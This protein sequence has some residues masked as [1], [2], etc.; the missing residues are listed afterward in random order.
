[1]P[2]AHD[3][4]VPVA[5]RFCVLGLVLTLGAM[6][7]TRT[8]AQ[9][10]DTIRYVTPEAARTRPIY[11]YADDVT[12]WN[13]GTTQVVALQGKVL[14]E[15]G[16]AVV[17][18]ERAVAWMESSH[19]TR[20]SR[21]RVYA[22]G[23][24]HGEAGAKPFASSQATLDLS[25]YRELHVKSYSRKI[26]RHSL[27]GSPLVQKAAEQLGIR[28]ATATAQAATPASGS[29]P[30]PQRNTLPASPPGAIAPT[31]N[32]P[33][34]LPEALQAAEPG[35]GKIV[36]TGG[37]IPSTGIGNGYPALPNTG[38][39][40][41]GRWTSSD[42]NAD[43]TLPRQMPVGP[44]PLDPV[45]STPLSRV[46]TGTPAGPTQGS[47]PDRSFRSNAPPP[48]DPVPGSSALNG[49]STPNGSTVPNPPALVP[50]APPP[51]RPN[52]PSTNPGSYPP[53]NTNVPPNPPPGAISSETV[54]PMVQNAL[55]RVIQIAP[56]FSV[57]FQLKFFPV[58]DNEQACVIT[59]GIILTVRFQ[60]A[61]K[62]LV[63]DM[64]AD[65]VVIWTRGNSQE[66]LEGMRA[67]QEQGNDREI[68]FYLQGNVIIRTSEERNQQ[69]LRADRVYYDV[70]K[71]RAIARNADLEFV[72]PGL[73]AAAHVKAEE[74]WQLSRTEYE[75]IQA[76]IFSS[77][78]P[79]NP[80]LQLSL[81]RLNI[82]ERQV[83]TRGW[84]EKLLTG[85]AEPE[86]ALLARQHYFRGRNAMLRVTEV[87]FFYLPYLQGDA[88]DP[89]GPL[90]GISFGQDVVFG[91]QVYTTWDLVELLGLRKRA[92]FDWN[93][94]A[95][96]LSE[97]GFGLGSNLDYASP[98]PS[99]TANPYRGSIK[100]YWIRDE[101]EDVLPDRPST[102]G[103]PPADRGR[104]LWRHIQDFGEEWSV[105]AQVSYLS[106]HNFL[107]Q[108][109]KFEFD[110]GQNQET[111]AYTKWQRGIYSASL[112]AQQNIRDWVTETSWLPRADGYITGLSLFD[113]FTYHSWASA[114]YAD[115]HVATG[116][117]V[118]PPTVPT[119][120]EVI[121]GRF[122]WMQELSLPF[123]LGPVKLAPYGRIDLTH[124]TK[125]LT[126]EDDSRFLGGGGLRASMPLSRL[127]PEARSELLNVNGIFHKIV[128]S[129]NYY[130]AHST[131]TYLTL[132]QLDR[133]NDDAVDQSLRDITPRQTN[134]VLGPAGAALQS[135]PIFN[136]QEYA[137]RRLIDHR[138][139]TLES[140]QVLQADIRQRWQTKRGYPGLEH[141]IDW[142]TLDVSASFFPNPI[143]DNYGKQWAFL[144]YQS[145]WYVGD[146]TGLSAT[147][148]FDPFENGASYWTLGGWFN[149][150]DRTNIYLGYRQID[151]IG[152]KAVIGSLTYAFSPKYAITASTTYDFGIQEALS[153]SLMITR[154]GTDMQISFGVTYNALINNFGIQFELVPILVPNSN[155]GRFIAN[156]PGGGMMSRSSAF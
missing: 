74:L 1:M 16:V 56:R 139:D 92:G 156:G 36:P 39:P 104:F 59:G 137:I 68:E 154:M 10:T 13:E 124:Y 130:A 77:K 15:Q 150:D 23:D 151:P 101:G 100:A 34:K 114:G 91:T 69:T 102:F 52:T 93:L 87:P 140:I 112:L 5:G 53:T 25:S 141:T 99:L 118:N 66:L 84:V 19:Q 105:Q 12:L 38:S 27:A 153:N 7:A 108:Y 116:K 45:P 132:P 49:S 117:A 73:P 122:D 4:G 47:T 31:A 28:P 50:G 131:T 32:A 113:R 14:I 20:L 121:T 67:G 78:L 40:Y 98:N 71:N 129:G 123:Q 72:Q 60:Q 65:Q 125:T 11:L 55:S 86:P 149:R 85:G 97:R 81:S 135:S 26:Q 83:D 120:V 96:Y 136:P 44:T 22:E 64:E 133:L 29:T 107:E 24:V 2:T 3:K 8:F 143:A 106:D 145:Y 21:V 62:P 46:P 35:N 144:E 82:E 57:P 155:F 76:R 89:L 42:A 138:V 109:Y 58:G 103:P 128:V 18:A 75:A 30:L 115:L 9:A 119:D 61:G 147:G 126:G 110:M 79:S 70:N 80:G 134:F 17:R 41:G 43:R 94:G 88:R 95:D 63:I 111:F 51:L 6:T 152:S 142:L 127:Y 54:I 148:W 90:Q 146:Q 48:L 37:Q 33:R